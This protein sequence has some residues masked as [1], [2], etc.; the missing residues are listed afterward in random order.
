MSDI[1]YLYRLVGG[2]PLHLV[3]VLLNF[4]KCSKLRSLLDKLKLL[5][6]EP[7]RQR[8]CGKLNVLPP[9]LV[10]SVASA[11]WPGLLFLHYAPGWPPAPC[12]KQ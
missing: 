11:L 10:V 5:V 9:N 6:V 3:L 7:N 12:I 1:L 8:P 2:L 4:A